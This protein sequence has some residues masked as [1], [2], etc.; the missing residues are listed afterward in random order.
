MLTSEIY[1][2]LS[3]LLGLGA[4]FLIVFFSIACASELI[5]LV[6]KA[7]LIPRRRRSDW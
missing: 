4:P 6:Q 1:F 3:K 7:A 5:A 2:Y